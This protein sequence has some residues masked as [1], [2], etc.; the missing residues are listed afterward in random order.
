MVLHYSFG[1]CHNARLL[2][3][4]THRIAPFDISCELRYN[5]SQ[6][7]DQALHV[8]FSRWVRLL[9]SCALLFEI[10]GCVFKRLFAL[11]MLVIFILWLVISYLPGVQAQLPTIAFGSGSNLLAALGVASLIVFVAIQLWLL[12]TTVS[13][14][15][16]FQAKEIRTPFRLKVGTEFFWTALPILM[17]VGLAWASYALWL[18]QSVP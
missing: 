9:C 14:I 2:V 11:S 15:R 1:K 12:V 7:G 8:L 18:G 16:T 3:Q 10:G 13:T 17:T 5:R 6:I 4:R